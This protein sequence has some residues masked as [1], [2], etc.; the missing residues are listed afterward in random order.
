MSGASERS[1]TVGVGPVQLPDYLDRSQIVTRT[2]GNE[3]ILPDFDKWAEPLDK[4]FVRVLTEDLSALRPADRF[5]AYPAP[6]P[7]DADYQLVVE[8]MQFDGAPDG[9]VALK[10]RWTLYGENRREPVAIRDSRIAEPLEGS[11][12][13][14]VVAAESKALA[15][16]SREIGE[17]LDSLP[18]EVSEKH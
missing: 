5:V 12:C 1:I 2:A 8:V 3:L 4:S 14:A 16:L 10:A 9:K 18:R 15:S 11:G 7:L 13:E 17:T 6:K